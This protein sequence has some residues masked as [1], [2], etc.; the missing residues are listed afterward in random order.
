MLHILEEQIVVEVN[1]VRET[2]IMMVM[3]MEVTLQFLLQTLGGRI[4][5]CVSKAVWSD[6]QFMVTISGSFKFLSSSHRYANLFHQAPG[7]V[8]AYIVAIVL[9]LAAHFYVVSSWHGDFRF[10]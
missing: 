3:W 10:S 9:K 1:P 6:Q 8:S 4:V 2:L 5:Q 7:T